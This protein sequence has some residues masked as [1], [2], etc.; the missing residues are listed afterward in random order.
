[1]ST[2]LSNT[3]NAKKYNCDLVWK[4]ASKCRKYS[5]NIIE[6]KLNYKCEI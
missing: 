6:L 4:F 5:S 3:K 1:M 2:D